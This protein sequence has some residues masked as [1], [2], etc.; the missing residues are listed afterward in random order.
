MIP[1]A[2]IAWLA[3]FALLAGG[4]A[5][6]TADPPAPTG[7]FVSLFN[8]TDLTGFRVVIDGAEASP[9]TTFTVRDSVLVISGTP[10][11]YITTRQSF[12][13]FALR[14]D[15]KFTDPAGGNSGLLVHIQQASHQGPWPAC[16]E[17]QGMQSEHG[18]ILP[19]GGASRSSRAEP[20]C[21]PARRRACCSRS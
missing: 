1:S 19:I 3:L 13:N 10:A 20:T 15:W 9:G 12:H 17:V 6:C 7:P 5:G 16:I 21:C 4:L 18:L 8:G 11:G 2:R 14:Y